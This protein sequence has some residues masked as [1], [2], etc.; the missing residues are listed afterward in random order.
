MRQ[1]IWRA[2]KAS[3][4]AVL[5]DG[6]YLMPDRED[7]LATLQG[8][9][10][11]VRDNGGQA[12]LVRVESLDGAD[13]VPLF[14]RSGDFAVLLGDV[15][16]VRQTLT[17]DAVQE[18]TRQARK[19][20]KAFAGLAAI[21][22]FPGEAQAQVDS[23][24]CEL[25]LAC[26][27]ILSPDEPQGQVGRISRLQIKDYQGRTWATRRRPWGDRLASAWLIRRFIDPAAP[28]LWLDSLAA[29]PDGVLG[30][31]FDGASFSHLDGRVTFEV[32]ASS[33][34]LEQAPLARLGLLVHY[35]DVGGVQPPEA[36]GIESV[37]AG[38]RESLLDD[39]Q[40]L[41]AASGV[42]DGLLA[43]FS[44]ENPKS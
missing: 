19:L 1:R 18:V 21:D 32:L 38:L 16:R 2:L 17:P 33:F 11:D 40:L 42:F 34:G 20:R 22:F 15:G 9:G 7:C 41:A 35:L 37:L 44:R 23:A 27:R 3:G 25:E 31:D 28:I 12:Y 30:F 14:D 39:D 24:L 10:V 5:R 43:N 13:F 26:S 6:V 4:A 36:V 8:L 29:C